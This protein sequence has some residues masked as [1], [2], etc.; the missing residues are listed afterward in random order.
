LRQEIL[1]RRREA[2]EHLGAEDAFGFGCGPAG[3]FV[4]HGL[5]GKKGGR[6]GKGTTCGGTR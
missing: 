2:L 3:S 1:E 5:R 6:T 4:V